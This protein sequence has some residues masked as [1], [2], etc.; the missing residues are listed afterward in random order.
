MPL[1]ILL[2]GRSASSTGRLILQLAAQAHLARHADTV[3]DA[4]T[5]LEKF[6]FA[7]V[8]ARETLPD[9]R[10]YDLARLIASQGEN[11]FVGVPL[12]ETL[13][14]PV[15]ERGAMV[16]GQR[17]ECECLRERGRNCAWSS[18]GAA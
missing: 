9:G 10:G 3:A 13:W 6:R 17:V 2:V 5:M 15:V 11:V 12:S 1:Q 14:L 4:K 8:L 7:V 18:S 16:L